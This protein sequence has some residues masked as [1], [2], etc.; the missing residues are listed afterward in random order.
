MKYKDRE[1]STNVEDRRKSNLAYEKWVNKKSDYSHLIS[2]KKPKKPN[3]NKTEN[4][5]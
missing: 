4:R 1:K 2:Y 5:G 3:S